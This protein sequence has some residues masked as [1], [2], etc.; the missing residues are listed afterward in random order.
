MLDW[1]DCWK[2]LSLLSAEEETVWTWPPPSSVGDSE[3][4]SLVEEGCVREDILVTTDASGILKA[5]S[6]ISL[7]L[8]RT[9]C[10]EK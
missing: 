6:V 7:H 5:T 9:S 2:M 4:S 3:S 10:A 8:W 1:E